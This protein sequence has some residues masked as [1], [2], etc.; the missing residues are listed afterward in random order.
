MIRRAIIL[1]LLLAAAAVA[2]AALAYALALQSWEITDDPW[3]KQ[4]LMDGWPGP[5][6]PEWKQGSG[7]IIVHPQRIASYSSVAWDWQT[8]HGDG[9]YVVHEF[10]V[11]RMGWPF[12]SLGAYR[13]VRIARNVRGTT[14]MVQWRTPWVQAWMNGYVQPP[15]RRGDPP[16]V[17]P[18]YPI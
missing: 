7:G 16:R 12:R 4:L 15:A 13:H 8:L 17:W 3:P 11:W 5:V 10:N 1:V 14:N 18:L 2:Q 6:P 9:D